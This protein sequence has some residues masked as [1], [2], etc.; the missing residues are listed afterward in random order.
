MVLSMWSATYGVIH[1]LFENG[2][3]PCSSM[4]INSVNVCQYIRSNS[5]RTLLTAFMASITVFR[6]GWKLV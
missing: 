6:R 5:E 1:N 3:C 4:L 2:Y